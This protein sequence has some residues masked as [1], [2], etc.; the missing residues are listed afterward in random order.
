[1][2]ALTSAAHTTLQAYVFS[3][4]AYHM[5]TLPALVQLLHRAYFILIVYTWF[6]AIDTGYFTT[7]QGIASKIV[8]KHLPN[9]IETSK[10]HLRLSHQH[11]RSTSSQPPLTPPPHPINQPMMTSVII[12]TDNPAR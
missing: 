8:R 6:K 2:S 9:S 1:M 3:N 12:H 10:G 11:I 5:N 4:S 7:W